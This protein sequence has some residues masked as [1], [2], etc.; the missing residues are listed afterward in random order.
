MP[1]PKSRERSA[2]THI[3]RPPVNQGLATALVTGIS[4]AV[5]LGA[6]VI[7]NTDADNQYNAG[8]IESLVGPI[9]DGR[10]EI[11]IGAR[12]IDSTQHFSWVTKRL[13]LVRSAVVRLAR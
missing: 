7:A 13:Q 1:H 9:L 5:G 4:V 2:L 6:D 11:V 12:P 3:V 8:D 10:A